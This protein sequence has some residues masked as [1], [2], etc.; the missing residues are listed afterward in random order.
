MN[1][2]FSKITYGIAFIA[3]M[4]TTTGHVHSMQ[5]QVAATVYFKVPSGLTEWNRKI[6]ET[7]ARI[8][9]TKKIFIASQVII[10]PLVLYTLL[11]SRN[12]LGFSIIFYML[13]G[14]ALTGTAVTMNLLNK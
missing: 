4:L 3:I 11:H 9:K 1:T 13:E 6:K 2:F 7:Q 8:E 5:P 10:S 14:L 12:P